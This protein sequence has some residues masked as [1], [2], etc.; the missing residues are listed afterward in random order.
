MVIGAS[1]KHFGGLLLLTL[2]A[3]A[4]D[5]YHLGADDAAIY[6]PAI[7]QVADPGLYPFGSEFFLCHAHL[8]LFPNLVGETSRLTR[9]PV[10]FA[11]FLWHVGGVFLLLLAAWQLLGACFQGEPARWGGVA[12]LAAAFSVPVAGTALA[13]MDPYLTARSLSTPATLFAVAS[14]A[15]G[16]PRRAAA[17]LLLTVL[18]H[19]QMALYGV[20]F[21]GC[22]ALFSAGEG[23]E[24][25]LAPAWLFSFPVLPRLFDLDPARGP[26]REALRSRTYFLVTNWTW[27][28][29]V[30]VFAPL[31]LCWWL[32]RRD[33]AGTTPV[34]RLILRALTPFGLLFTAAGLFLA[35]SPRLENLTRLQ[36]MRALHLVYLVFFVFLGGML[37]EYLLRREP[38]RWLA[39]FLPLASSM[40]LLQLSDYPA[41]RHVEWPGVSDVSPWGSAFYWIRHNV[42]KDAVFAL[43]PGYML[44]Q[45][46]DQ[47]GFRAIAERSVLADAVK[48]SGAVS[49]FPNL[50]EHWKQ[51]VDAQR[52]LEAFH[53]EGFQK[54]AGLFPVT[55]IVT[56]QA[57]PAGLACPYRNAGLS[58]CRIDL[59][60]SVRPW[61]VPL[62]P[63]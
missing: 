8:S 50:A 2:I 23:P 63:Q 12:L 61:D 40:W 57:H 47:H 3:V 33:T 27:Y 7:K 19:P 24:E 43:D 10:D 26:A 32:S 51:Q 21:L 58:V 59:V 38:W 56:R 41:S 54:L 39:L 45:G 15:A 48:D 35:A 62:P 9:I 37:G 17:W 36:P 20:V 60:R 34:F 25:S 5:G 53:L 13:L 29:W 1:Q 22:L 49:L 28:E 46:E 52:G 55:W 42:P 30:G 16:K 31:A 11:I 14:Y 4:V 18:I 6:V 44:I